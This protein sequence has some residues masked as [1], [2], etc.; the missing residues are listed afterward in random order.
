MLGIESIIR[1]LSILSYF[2]MFIASVT[3]F[4]EAS[5]ISTE[6][7]KVCLVTTSLILMLQ[8]LVYIACEMLRLYDDNKIVMDNLYF[9][10][11]LLII[12]SSILALGVSQ[13]GLG[14]G[15]FGILIFL[16]NIFAG[17]FIESSVR[18]GPYNENSLSN[19][20][21]LAR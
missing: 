6:G 11:S 15:I 14:F 8:N 5:N 9:I 12:Q 21:P 20:E 1:F 18:V 3:G 7:Y 16:L 13:V 10:R 19:E 4:V 17:V 2:G